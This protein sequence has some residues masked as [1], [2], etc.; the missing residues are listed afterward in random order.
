MVGI[1]RGLEISGGYIKGEWQLALAATN[2]TLYEP[3]LG[4]V[5]EGNV[6]SVQNYVIV[7]LTSGSNAG[8]RIYVL[9]QTEIGPVT[10]WATI[11]AGKPGAPPPIAFDD[12]MTSSA[13]QEYVFVSC[14][15]P[16]NC[17]FELA[18]DEDFLFPKK[19]SWSLPEKK[20]RIIEADPPI[21]HCSEYMNC[22]SCLDSPFCGWCSAKVIY[23]GNVLGGQCAGFNPNTTDLPF[24]CVGSYSIVKCPVPEPTYECNATTK[25][26]SLSKTGSPESICNATCG[27]NSST[28]LYKCNVA[29][30]TCE[31]D[32]GGQSLETC[33]STCQLQPFPAE[34]NGVYR[35]LEVSQNYT[36]GEWRL[37]IAAYNNSNSYFNLTDPR[38]ITLSGYM[39][40]IASEAVLRVH[41]TSPVVADQ[42]SLYQLAYGPET[43]WQM[44][45][46][47]KKI[48]RHLWRR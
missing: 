24:V 7:T 9:Y 33:N 18:S 38:N 5:W 44:A 20:V 41:I 3:N 6:S 42:Y 29:N 22:T 2:A 17:K 27:K 10:K 36:D 37:S 47:A 25:T 26:C 34:L 11:A 1:W 8:L 46:Q 32:N 40:H 31:P 43:S 4:I 21:D 14:L 28:I 30:M 39:D 16:S 48:I 23:Q 35:G 15:D 13:A 19:A 45:S 12:A